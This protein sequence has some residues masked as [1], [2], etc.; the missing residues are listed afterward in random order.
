LDGLRGVAALWVMA[1]HFNIFFLPQARLSSVVPF[2]GRAY[3]A[4]DLFFLLSGFVMAHVYGRLL[5]SNWRAHWRH[6]A[7]ARFARL[8]PLFAITTLVVVALVELYHAPVGGVSFSFQSLALQPIMLQQ[9][10]SGLS[11]DYP[12]WSISTEAEAYLFFLFFS[13]FLLSGKCPRLMA[14][15]SIAVL[16]T[17][18]IIQGGGIN[19]FVGLPALLRTLAGFSLGVLIY[20]FYSL[21]TGV[22]GYW[23]G[24]VAVLLLGL[25]A[26]THIDTIA[27]C[28]FAFIVYGCAN[29]TN[30]FARFLDTRP[31]VALGNWSYSVYL[32]H[33]PMSFAVTGVLAA[34]HH[35]V[36]QL[37]ML[38]ARLLLFTTAC[39]V[40]IV[41]AFHYR[42]VETPIRQFVR[43]STSHLGP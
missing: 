4:V 28:G 14:A 26:I 10:C 37:D 27:V 25:A 17:L 3:L 23:V 6:F 38:R 21:R 5:A 12:S 36:S 1:F 24:V 20:R 30:V 32:W 19:Y 43:R 8:Y 9:W 34:A 33:A 40:V 39:A 29:A 35:P 42:F 15:S 16:S 13:G 18:G 11:W 2:L 7:L 41:A 31:L 22:A